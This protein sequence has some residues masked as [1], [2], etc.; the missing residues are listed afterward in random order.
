MSG[1]TK[2]F[3]SILASTVWREPMETRIV[4]ITLLAMADKDGVA[5]ASIPGL[6]DFARIPVEDT[7]EALKRLM[8]PDKD[9]RSKEYEGRRIEETDGGWIL[10]NHAKYRAK[11]GADERREYNRIKQSQYRERQ[12]MSLTVSENVPCVD[13][14]KEKASTD[15]KEIK[16]KGFVPPTLEEVIEYV[17]TRTIKISPEGFMDWHIGNGWKTGKHPMKDWKAVVRTWE[18]R[19]KE[20]PR[21]GDWVPPQNVPADYVPES[22]KRKRELEQAR[23]AGL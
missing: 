23:L 7:R 13:N 5:E 14:T 8:A 21:K 3:N 2:L 22:V 12:K 1:Y 15:S 18:Q 16:A 9:S 19:R 11:M 4:W 10:L 6:A 17:K 20:N